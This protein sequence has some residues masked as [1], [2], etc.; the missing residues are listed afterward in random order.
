MKEPS[1]EKLLAFLEG[2]MEEAERDELLDALDRDPALAGRL[3]AAAAG[4]EAMRTLVTE[5]VAGREGTVAAPLRVSPWWIAAAAAV[6]LLVAVPLTWSAAR[7]SLEGVARIDPATATE[8]AAA[9]AGGQ[10]GASALPAGGIPEP[11]EPSYLLMLHGTWP[12]A[13]AVEPA[14][15]QARAREY[16]GWTASLAEQG[17][18]MAAGN[19]RWEAGERL[20][21]GGEAIPVSD[22]EVSTPSYVVG[23][24]ALRVGS[25]EEALEIARQ[26]PHLRYGGTV[27]VRQVGAGFVTIPGMSDW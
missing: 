10:T 20:G 13:A 12:D 6:T 9:G 27:S 8:G 15:R 23:M 18:L 14:E 4:L 19:L 16:W 1:D 5:T 26:C 2:D 17:V 25:Y 3:R 24:L 7:A 11:S 22:T 21:P